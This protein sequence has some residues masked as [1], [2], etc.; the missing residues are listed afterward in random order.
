MQYKTEGA[1]AFLPSRQK[2]A[3]SLELKLQAVRE[4]LAGSESLIEVS[5]GYGLRDKKQLQN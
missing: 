3:Y 1:A 4:Y 2:H 5:E